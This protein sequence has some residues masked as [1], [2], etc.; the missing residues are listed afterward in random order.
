MI[1]KIEIEQILRLDLIE[2]LTT[3]TF[4]HYT[5]FDTAIDE[6]LLKNTLQFSDPL[7]FNDPFDC[8]EKLL[9]VSFDQELVDD[10]LNNLSVK[11]SRQEKR[12]LIRKFNNPKT[13]P[14][15]LKNERKKYKI[16]CFS[17]FH[18]EILMWSHYAAKHS[19]ICIG[20]DFPH[21]YDE[22]FIMCP[23]K[24][25]DELKPID[26]KTDVLRVIMY[27]LT[28]KSIR[29]DYEKEIR[30]IT[31]SKSTNDYELLR[32][33]PIYIKEI[34]FGC[35][36]KD[37]DIENGLVKLKRGGLKIDNIVVKR[38]RIDEQNFLLKDEII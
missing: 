14:E 34:I 29:W 31:K 18:N 8:N 11:L 4:Y 26:G 16:T 7:T 12:E 37:K 28:T 17:K 13:F 32:F 21:K 25:L 27:W 2:A 33:D 30:A 35:N 38:M 24:Y 36:V 5:K 15:I 19:G 3:K 23:V 22:N 6:I 1:S 9:K 20:F 10:T